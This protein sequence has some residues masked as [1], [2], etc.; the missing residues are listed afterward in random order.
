MFVDIFETE[1]NTNY[2][3]SITYD[4]IRSFE[5][6]SVFVHFLQS[7]DSPS[8][9]LDRARNKRLYYFVHTT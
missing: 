2:K 7:T 8:L 6:A 1:S 9:G 4:P 3:K 5:M